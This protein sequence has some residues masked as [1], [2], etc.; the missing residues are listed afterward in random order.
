M[1]EARRLRVDKFVVWACG[2]GIVNFVVTNLGVTSCGDFSDAFGGGFP[3]PGARLA[4]LRLLIDRRM[5]AFGC[6]RWSGATGEHATESRDGRIPN[7][8]G[9]RGLA[10]TENLEPLRGNGGKVGGAAAYGPGGDLCIIWAEINT[11][12]RGECP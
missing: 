9:N 1:S 7:T 5:R 12:I 11:F 4:E 10:Q 6:R 3:A 8:H 2:E